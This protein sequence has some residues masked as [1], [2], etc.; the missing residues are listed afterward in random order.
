M[1]KSYRTSKQIINVLAEMG[2]KEK[3]N[4]PFVEKEVC[5]HA[6]R[7]KNAGNLSCEITCY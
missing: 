2:I 6:D 3:D 1:N 5:N 4:F 7:G